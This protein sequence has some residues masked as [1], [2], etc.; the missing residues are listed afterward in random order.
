MLE[1][2][3]ELASNE[4]ID[5]VIHQCNHGNIVSVALTVRRWDTA[6]VYSTHMVGTRV[7]GDQKERGGSG[8][9]GG[10]E[11]GQDRTEN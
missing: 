7:V 10:G 6:S 8:V 4:E 5:R 3:R 2:D 11:G 9:Y 1:P